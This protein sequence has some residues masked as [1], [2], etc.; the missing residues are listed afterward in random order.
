MQ[1]SVIKIGAFF[2]MS[3]KVYVNEIQ[4]DWEFSERE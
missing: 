2:L 1:I 3:R 4:L